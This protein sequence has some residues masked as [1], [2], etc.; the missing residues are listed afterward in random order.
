MIRL[1]SPLEIT[2]KDNEVIFGGE[3]SLKLDNLMAGKISYYLADALMTKNYAAKIYSIELH[4]KSNNYLMTF[5]K[6]K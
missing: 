3:F 5:S 1:L 4:G 2:V 6:A